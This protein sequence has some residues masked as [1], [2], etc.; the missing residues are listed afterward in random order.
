MTWI[1]TRP[2]K[3]S[4]ELRCSL[5]QQL[6]S[7]YQEPL[8]STKFSLAN[9]RCTEAQ[10]AESM[11]SV[12]L[13][14][15]PALTYRRFFTTPRENPGIPMASHSRGGGHSH[16]CQVTTLLRL[17]LRR[18]LNVRFGQPNS[19]RLS[20][21]HVWWFSHASRLRAATMA[22]PNYQM[23]TNWDCKLWQFKKYRSKTYHAHEAV[24][25]R[26]RRLL[27]SGR[28]WVSDL[29]PQVFPPLPGGA[30]YPLAR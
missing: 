16:L 21:V 28:K 26:W 18:H 25:P 7:G 29:F 20:P 8:F 11:A 23:S 19:S 13:Q 10:E 4:R 12:P 9:L 6:F 14:K 5:R 27:S 15:K 2:A 1:L 24:C 3:S 22:S 17:R 30:P